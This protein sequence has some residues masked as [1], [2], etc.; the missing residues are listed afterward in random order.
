ME[1][2]IIFYREDHLH[3]PPYVLKRIQHPFSGISTKNAWPL[4]EP[5]EILA[6]PGLV[7]PYQM[8]DLYSLKNIKDIKG[9]ERPNDCSRFKEI[10]ELNAIVTLDGILD[11]KEK[12]T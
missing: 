6:D 2:Y 11:Q 7:T 4:S 8:K 10:L 1:V 5:K 3:K 12:D 9:R